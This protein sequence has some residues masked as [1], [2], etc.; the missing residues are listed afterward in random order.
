MNVFYYYK[1]QQLAKVNSL[2]IE[3]GVVLIDSVSIA[4]VN[5]F[6]LFFQSTAKHPPDVD[7]N[8]WTFLLFCNCQYFELFAMAIERYAAALLIARTPKYLV[9]LL[10][11]SFETFFLAV[12]GVWQTFAAFL[13]YF[14]VFVQFFVVFLS[15]CVCVWVQNKMSAIVQRPCGLKML[16]GIDKYFS[17]VCTECT[18]CMECVAKYF[19]NKDKTKTKN[20]E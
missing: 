4:I 3:F 19:D 11:S 17:Q 8:R 13:E 2:C 20:Q 9:T 5:M 15:V 7:G 14:R 18:E 12:R 1:F 6:Q 16:H 10:K